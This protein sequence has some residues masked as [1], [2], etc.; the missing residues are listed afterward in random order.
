M[1]FTTIPVRELVDQ[2]VR[3]QLDIPEFQRDFVWRPDQVKALADS[4]FRDYPIGQ[5]LTWNNPAYSAS[6]GA[7]GTQRP[8][9]WLVDGQQRT[10]ALCLLFG[11]KP[12]WWED[13]TTWNRRLASTQVLANVCSGTSDVEFG[14]ANPVRLGDPKWTSVRELVTVEGPAD[15]PA[16]ARVLNEGADAIFRK[17]P[18]S[19]SA[20]Y[21]VEA[22]RTRLRSIWEIG[23][24][25]I[26]ISDVHHDIEDVAE[27]FTRLNQQGTE[28]AEAD[29]SLAVA[30]TRHPGW[31]REQFLPF[32]KNLSESG[33][34]L[35]P[36]VIIRVLTAIGEGKARLGE[37][38]QAFWEGTGFDDAWT[39]TKES[40]SAM[41]SAMA[42]VGIL[43]SSILPSR[44]AV[45]PLAVLHWKLGARGFHFPRALHWFLMAA[46]DGR[47]SGA[48]ATALS[49][50]VKTIRG[51]SDFAEAIEALR[52]N[53]EV[54]YRLT[55][56]DFLERDTW[57]RPLLLIAYLTIFD[58]KATDWNSRRR[59]GY[60]RADGA[61]DY[62]YVP[63]WH[64]FFPRGRTVLRSPTFDYTDDEVGSVANLVV[65]NDKPK[66]RRWATSAPSKYLT[67]TGVTD[68]QLDEQMLPKEKGLWEP[69]RY[70]DF[71]AARAKLLAAATNDYL[72]RLLGAARH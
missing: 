48:S 44:N 1:G 33:Y 15:S 8:K 30:A 26:A 22:I 52:G 13:T 42:G 41:V 17:L 50:D 12:Y 21:P 35:E 56:Q 43:S 2:A 40:L 53:L 55:A 47:Y 3:G 25:P 11:R 72:A 65:L 57:N 58:R 51:A 37:V 67:G 14:L 36:G 6:R 18:G 24:R 54:D 71:L 10:T 60:S 19:L 31:V 23:S 4:L 62:G 32:L 69:D 7:T 70:R 9:L 5:I 16:Q 39:H 27:I 34:D 29:V 45:V 59:I 49:A 64:S 46:R 61:L 28:V 38:S 66:D 63:Y 20:K 68:R